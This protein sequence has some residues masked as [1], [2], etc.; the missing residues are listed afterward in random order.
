VL[1]AGGEATLIVYEQ[2]GMEYLVIMAGGHHFYDDATGRRSDRVRLAGQEV[3]SGQTRSK[4][5]YAVVLVTAA[6]RV[7]DYCFGAPIK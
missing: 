6:I 1:P 5:R 4:L 3:N 7:R 2:D